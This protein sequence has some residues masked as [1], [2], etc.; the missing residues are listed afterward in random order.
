MDQTEDYI[1]ISERKVHVKLKLDAKPLH[2]IL[3]YG[4]ENK[5]DVNT[6]ESFYEHRQSMIDEI[7]KNEYMIIMGDFSTRVGIY[8]DIT[9][10]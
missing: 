4:P 8:N 7:T 3:I 5:R 2:I 6:R 10:T 9:K 1:Y